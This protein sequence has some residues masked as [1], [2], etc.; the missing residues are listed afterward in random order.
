MTAAPDR[1]RA[2]S[3]YA[4][5]R[6]RCRQLGLPTWRLDTGGALVE[7]PA[8]PGPAG[9]W[10]RS[11][12]IQ[13]LVTQSA[14]ARA[15]PGGNPKGDDPRLGARATTIA[16][17]F[18][19]AWLIALPEERRGRRMGL[20]V[21]LALGEAALTGATFDEACRAAQLDPPACRTALRRVARFDARSARA[22]ADLLTWMAQDLGALAD[23][24]DA[25]QGFT[26]EL[27]QS[28][29]TITLLYSL[30]NCMRDL[31]QP[32][33]FVAIVCDKIQDTIP[34][35]WLACAFLDDERR[36]GPLAG[37]RLSRG[38]ARLG[39]REIDSILAGLAARPGPYRGEVTKTGE[40]ADAESR[41]LVQPITRDG[42]LAGALMTGDK[43]GE[44]TQLSSY[45]TQLLEAAAAYIGAFLDNAVLY[46]DQQRM[47]VGSLRALTASIDAKDRYT[48]GH[49]ERVAHVAARLAEAAGLDE[50]QAERVHICGLV[51]DV[52]KIGVPES[53]LTKPGRLTEEEFRQM[54]LHPEIGHRILKDIPQLEDILPGVLHH[55]ERWDGK[56][57][58]HGL[59]GE[60]IPRIARIIGLADAFD[61]MSS[62]RSYR[63]A[64]R[65]DRVLAE[66][67]ACSGTQF[68]PALVAAFGRVDL[69]GYDRLAAR[70]AVEHALHPSALPSSDT[71]SDKGIAAGV[72]GRAAA[73]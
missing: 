14:M 10:V 56:G 24:Q 52:G 51:H 3:A 48:C 31:D 60:R 66:I 33:R 22:A 25:V 1:E 35:A 13:R 59:S 63:A 62:N 68:D 12:P 47:F 38:A 28:Y 67:A 23:Y 27:T 40:G 70:H 73:A 69:S 72:T 26:S 21:A 39:D 36:C 19:G 2:S 42:Q 64:V 34:F 15:K 49:S 45:D 7:E 44:D 58:P 4:A 17:L 43:V 30:G 50:R 8:E 5:V 18:E 57:Y 32:D 20:T 37:R 6:D 46:A 41:V 16:A 9:L 11:A 54:R 71:S 55:H 65:R 29:E 61:A 53:V